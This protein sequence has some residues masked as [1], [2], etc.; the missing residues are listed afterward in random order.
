MP[1]F[2]KR[3][4]L[5]WSAFS[6]QVKEVKAIQHKRV[7]RCPV[8]PQTAP[9]PS[10]IRRGSP[11]RTHGCGVPPTA[12][13]FPAAR[14][15][16]LIR[17]T[18][19]F[20]GERGI[21]P[22]QPASSSDEPW[23]RRPATSAPA[24]AAQGPAE[25]GGQQAGT[26]ST[27]GGFPPPPAAGSRHNRP[28]NGTPAAREGGS[29][30]LGLRKPNGG[31]GARA[32]RP[33]FAASGAAAGTAALQQNGRWASASSASRRCP[34][35]SPAPSGG[36]GGGLTPVPSGAAAERRRRPPRRRH[37]RAL[38]S[39]HAPQPGSA[40]APGAAPLQRGRALAVGALAAA[41]LGLA[42]GAGPAGVGPQRHHPGRP[43]A[44]LP[45][46]AAAHRL[47][48]Q[49]HR[50]GTGPPP[51]PSSPWEPFSRLTPPPPA[52]G[53][54]SARRPLPR[55]RV[56]PGETPPPPPPLAPVPP[57]GSRPEL[58]GPWP[59]TGVRCP[60]TPSRGREG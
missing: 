6:K 23:A 1:Q 4:Y 42:G 53:L 21:Q 35:L 36:G 59:A 38:G 22:T 51:P 33:A 31:P 10:P 8:T 50:A 48:P 39:A 56:P 28:R 46:G 3:R 14:A 54:A 45:D 34:Q 7:F 32:P 40:E 9:T 19:Q 29:R 25:N 58:S 44:E 60:V 30:A 52:E 12:G 20:R 55:Q 37:G 47:L 57:A 41:L 5:F 18:R 17:W 49:R 2:P 13:R 26:P 16:I 24:E 43:P 27:T 11:P 15:H